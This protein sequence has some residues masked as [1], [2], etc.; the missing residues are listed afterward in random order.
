MTENFVFNFSLK[1]HVSVDV[2]PGE[3]DLTNHLLP[4]QPM[5]KCLFPQT[6]QYS[7]IRS[8]TNP[9][10]AEMDG[11]LYELSCSLVINMLLFSGIIISGCSEHQVRTSTTFSSL[12]Q[13]KID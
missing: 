1:R 11:V 5:N 7:Q 2:M 10:E 3:F 9:Y 4:Q 13:L 8:V 12:A 6:A